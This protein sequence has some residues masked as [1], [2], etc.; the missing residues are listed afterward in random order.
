MSAPQKSSLKSA[1]IVVA[2][3][4]V[5]L[6][7]AAFIIKSAP[8]PERVT[9]EV[10]ARL[11]E[12]ADIRVAQQLPYWSAGGRV[13]ASQ[14][15]DLM[16][17]VSGRIKSIAADA[18]P[19]ARLSKGALLAE[20]DER[21]YRLAM[22]QRQAAYAQAVA[23]LKIEKGQAS[24][25]REEY[26]LAAAQLSAEDK[27]LVLRE[28]QIA[29]AQAEVQ[30]AKANLDQA[31]LNLERTRIRMPFD[32]QI[33]QRHI[34]V[35]S[36]V[37]VSGRAFELVNTDEFWIEVKI[38]A[39]FLP[40]LDPQQP[41]LIRQSGWLASEVRE[42]QVL[43]VLPAVDS[44]DRQVKVL[45]SLSDPLALENPELAKVLLND[46]VEVQLFGRL[47]QPSYEIAAQLI[48]NNNQIWVV[49]DGQL[50]QRTVDVLYRGRELSWVASDLADSDEASGV[51][52][53]DK[54]LI[55]KVDAAVA[56]APVRVLGDDSSTNKAADNDVDSG[57]DEGVSYD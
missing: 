55:S 53:G 34:S 4:L 12:V 14:Q 49:N 57:K 41:A 52:P 21:D 16:P 10:K 38:P 43:N 7:I 9:P 29:Q 32:G 3:L 33:N 40:L 18:I 51:Q 17:E 24:L 28:P 13:M 27:A 31:A 26:E 35:G 44:A 6:A 30:T 54:L 11:V 48:D 46:F 36:Q 5:G 50:Q 15:V 8:R 25:A 37:S 39:A 42:A 19:G 2:V 22:A 45:L 47:N 1:M 23:A 56:G 20:I